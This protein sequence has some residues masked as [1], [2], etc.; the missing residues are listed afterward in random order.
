MW[1]RSSTTRRGGGPTRSTLQEID[2]RG[3]TAN[4]PDFPFYAG[5]QLDAADAGEHVI[6]VAANNAT[7]AAGISVGDR[8]TYAVGEDDSITFEIGHDRPAQQHHQR[9]ERPELRAAGPD[10][11]PSARP[12]VRV[13]M[14]VN[15]SQITG[16][17]RALS[18]V[19]GVFVLETE[20]LNDL[21]NRVIDQFSSFP[22]LVAGWRCSRGAS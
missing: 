14:S 7:L 8:L 22:I 3:V 20:S 9:A 1:R 11:P 16:L 15:P 10:P 13:I 18:N 4:L 21:L 19:R 17:R 6:V 12:D 5:R 2:A